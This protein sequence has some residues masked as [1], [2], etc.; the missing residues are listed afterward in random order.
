[1]NNCGSRAQ[2]KAE[3]RQAIVASA[4]RLFRQHGIEGTSVADVMSDAGLTHGGFYSH[5]ADKNALVAEAFAFA[6]RQRDS[7]FSG[8]EN[9]DRQGWLARVTKRYLNKR[10]RD[11]PQEGCPFPAMC[12]E[13]ADLP[14]DH[15]ASVDAAIEEAVRRIAPNVADE[16]DPSGK[17]TA[18]ALLSLFAG[19]TLLSRSV[20]SEAL[21][22]ALLEA[23]R[24]FVLPQ[25]TCAP[26]HASPHTQD[27]REAE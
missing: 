18:L 8:L 5:F 12:Y 27:N 19:A 9:S 3:T 7:W 4:A 2:R 22:D 25:D 1:M 11:N 10:H 20:N 16:R 24:R 6:A 13:M 23:G 15:R 14:K 26:S 21:A 17:H